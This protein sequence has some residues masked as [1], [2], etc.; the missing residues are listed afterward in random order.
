MFAAKVG[1]FLVAVLLNMFWIPALRTP[2]YAVPATMSA[3]YVVFN[4]Y[5]CLVHRMHRRKLTFED[6][7]DLHDADPDMRKRFQRVFT[8]VQQT[9]GTL[10]AGVLVMYGFHVFEN[11]TSVFEFFGILGGLLSL[12]A[13][14]FG[15]IGSFSITCLHRLKG[16]ADGSGWA[17]QESPP[18]ADEPQQTASEHYVGDH[19]GMVHD[20]RK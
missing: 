9:G 11:E 13:R 6:L 5:P 19:V 10:C 7:E 12:Y 17:A 15:Y 8:R 2:L 14:I 1:W 16:R 4:M 20:T 18:D 3:V